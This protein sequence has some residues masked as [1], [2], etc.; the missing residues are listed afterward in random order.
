M[1]ATTDR[2]YSSGYNAEGKFTLLSGAMRH[3][4]GDY[5]ING[6]FFV[7]RPEGSSSRDFCP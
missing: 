1:S 4:A 2:I 5:R 7:F 3:L 6:T